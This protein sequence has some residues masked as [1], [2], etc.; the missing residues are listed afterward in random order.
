M[1][2]RDEVTLS[3]LPIRH[4]LHGD[5]EWVVHA[6]DRLRLVAC[7]HCGATYSIDD[8]THICER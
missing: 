5:Y 4:E 6:T 2:E 1:V 3:G 8:P 7:P